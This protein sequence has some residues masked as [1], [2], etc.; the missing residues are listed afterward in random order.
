MF[1]N[2][3]EDNIQKD[4]LNN[5]SDDYE[6]SAGYPIYDLTKA[7]SIEE[8][9][10]Y[11]NLKKV[12]DKLD[13]NNL[14]DSELEKFIY[15]RTGITR[16]PG[17]YAHTD[18]TVNGTT[19]VSEGAIFQT[20]A[21]IQFVCTKQTTITNSGTIPIQA[22][23]IGSGSN[24]PSNAITQM[25]V[26]I[27]GIIFIT[28][29]QTITN[30]YDEENDDSLRQR[31]F[32][33][34]RTPATSGN[35]YQYKNWCKDVT[36]VGDAKIIPL[37]NGN[38]TVKAIIMNS[39]K[40][41]ADNELIQKVKDYIDPDDG[42]GEGQAPIGA[43]LTVVSAVEKVIDASAKIVL[44]GGYTLQQ[45]QDG[46]TT[47]VQ[48]YLNDIVFNST[49]ISYAKIGNLLFSTPGVLDYDSSSLILNNG[50]I[51]VPLAN[52]EIPVSG[53]INLGV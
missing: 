33:R 22:L 50:T 49:Y 53:S 28:N 4:L 20:P 18:L 47:L 16:K 8:A 44:A 3:T 21:G 15:Q 14:S 5:I 52:E 1:E 26:T 32:E 2:K 37:W 45:V 12:L 29:L 40:R 34:L 36:G 35:K 11:K 23:Q 48:N 6:K 46:F 30:G 7:Y 19:T 9:E 43:T 17:G 51:N 24:V 25:P 38:G 31:Y 39:N 41:A 42:K 27:K 10:S 13:V